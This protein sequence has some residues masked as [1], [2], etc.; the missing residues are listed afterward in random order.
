[1]SFLARISLANKSIIA[2]ATIA[3]LLFGVYVIPSIKQELYPSLEFPAVSVIAAYPGAS[4]A[5]V[6]RD[7]TNPLEQSIQGIQGIQQVTSYSNQ[8]AAVILVS[9]NFGTDLDKASQTLTQ[10][11]NVAHE[12]DTTGAD[13][14]Y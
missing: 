3:I 13:V 10:Q 6:E 7:V 5:I 1:M 14:Q 2:L 4:P 8:G 9:Y 11:V 12:C